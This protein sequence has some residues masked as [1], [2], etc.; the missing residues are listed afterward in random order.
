MTE[1]HQIR[2]TNTGHVAGAVVQAG[3][4]SGGIHVHAAPREVV[5]PRQLLAA[6]RW[7]VGRVDEVAQLSRLLGRS[8]QSRPMSVVAIYGT[9]GIGKTWLALHWA[10]RCL[11][12]FPDGQLY[13][14]LRGFDPAGTPL[15][16]AE[17]LRGF[18]V[19]LGI[20]PQTVPATVDSQA[21]L[22]R[23]LMAGRRM[24]V[25]LDNARDTSHVEL[26][27]PGT[28]TCTVVV[29][30][31]HQLP[32][33]IMNHSAH[34]LPLSILTEPEAR[35]ML[36]LRIGAD[37]A[38]AE[39]EALAELTDCCAG[40][41]LAIGIVA[42]RVAL[43]PTIPLATLAT[44]LR[45][46]SARLDALD[47]G[48]IRANLRAVFSWSY[49]ALDVEQ[50]IV[51]RF[52]GVAPGQDID[53]SAVAS[54]TALSL[55]K[56]RAVLQDLERFSL[57]RQGTS[58][59]YQVHDLVKLYAVDRSSAVDT[60]D[61]RRSALHR[62]LDHYLHSAHAAARL[63]DP[64]TRH[65]EFAAVQRGVLPAE[66]ANIREARQ[67]WEAEHEV[68]VAAVARAGNAGFHSHA[69]Q[70]VWTLNNFFD[71]SG[72]WRDW[73]AT[74]EVAL[75]SARRLGN[76]S[77]EA[78]ICRV[79]GRAR[80]LL[81]SYEESHMHLQQALDLFQQ[82]GDQ[83]GAAPTHHAI[84]LVFEQQGRFEEALSH[85]R[86]AL[87]LQRAVGNR[88]G[89]AIALNSVGWDLAQLG[90]HDDALAYCQQA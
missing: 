29:T 53:L 57:I 12:E 81:G 19:A 16:P 8:A 23:S 37:R 76:R 55:Q 22:Y 79:L 75:D 44:G 60:E 45:D 90:H 47:T 14:N 54:L 35:E 36:T 25:I 49:N 48:E 21:S 74:Q 82:V 89:E 69:W 32:G 59:R 30:S 80:M 27:L 84:G 88:A 6:P 85:M 28:S 11:E 86:R 58:G 71:R 26:L 73:V 77:V 39:P 1:G 5:A 7:F 38:D 31:R 52:L 20:E 33:L 63:L 15:D 9:G 64:Q 51:F 24:L 13:V 68:L 65:P 67:W 18:L 72:H 17:A 87:E 78:M 10:H 66:L 4:I 43:T 3:S 46:V 62:V 50:A 2:N 40:L 34:P 61:E 56:A 41:P 70:L 42:A 83:A